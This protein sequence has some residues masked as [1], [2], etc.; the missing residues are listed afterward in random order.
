MPRPDSGYLNAA[1]QQVPGVS[2]IVK[3]YI[4]KNALVQWAYW[5][6]RNGLELYEKDVLDVGTTVH[7]L[8]ELN[9]KGRPDREIEALLH[10]ALFDAAAKA[11]AWTAY[12]HFCS[13]REQHAVRSIAH[14][15]NLVSETHQLGGTPDCIAYVDG[16]L[17][18]I[19]FKSCTKAPPKPYEEQVLAMAAHATLW[20]EH[21]PDQI[22]RACHIVYLPKD[23]SPHKH[24]AHANYGAQWDEFRHLL[25]AFQTKHNLPKPVPTA[26][27]LELVAK[28]KAKPRIRVRAGSSATP[29]FELV[30]TREPTEVKVE[31]RF[32]PLAF[33]VR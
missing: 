5:R 28:P 25:H 20:N 27:V 1:G 15:V 29:V 11:K 24:H 16:E 17:G 22:V 32:L 8:A 13:W 9:L 2:D 31:Q 14:E 12:E 21:H 33:S 6:G 10:S 3:A 30:P 4:P 7:A 18:L 23:G 26:P 19:D